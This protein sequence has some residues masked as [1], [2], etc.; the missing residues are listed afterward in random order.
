MK[1]E[2]IKDLAA[3]NGPKASSSLPSDDLTVYL[4]LE[5]G[6]GYLLEDHW[7]VYRY[8]PRLSSCRMRVPSRQARGKSG[9]FPQ[10]LSSS[11]SP[12]H[13]QT[14]LA[15]ALSTCPSRSKGS[16]RWLC[17]ISESGLANYTF[18]QFAC[19]GL[20]GFW[21]LQSLGRFSSIS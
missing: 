21:D 7:Q 18:A 11:S 10:S 14:R 16:R 3:I 12:R 19:K 4:Q 9:I 15:P 8:H 17:M 6:E 13:C 5:R 1:L 2:R 20:Q